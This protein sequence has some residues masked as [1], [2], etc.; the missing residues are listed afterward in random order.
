MPLISVL[1]GLAALTAISLSLLWN[2]SMSYGLARNGAE[3]ASRQATIEAAVNRAVV[4]LLDPQPDR[5][6]R[7]DGVPQSFAFGGTSMQVSIQDEL[8]KIDLNHAEGPVFAALLQSAGLDREAAARLADKMLDWR[9]ATSLKNLNGAKAPEYDVR[10]LT[11]RPRNGPFQSVDEL[12]L[13]MDMTPDLFR[14]IEPA[15]TVYA[16]HQFVDPKVAPREVLLAQPNATPDHVDSMLAAR[17][18]A[19]VAAAGGTSLG[20]RAFTIRV[21]LQTSDRN[22]AGEAAVRLTDNSAQPYWLLKWRM[23]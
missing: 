14:R 5:R 3:I 9:S 18:G 20:G 2:G 6:W 19:A 4:A 17:S 21:Q 13:V 12:L 8:G 22:V 10:G 15:L 23:R 16:G 7:T 1:W 11:I